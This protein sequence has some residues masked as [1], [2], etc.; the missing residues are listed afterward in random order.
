M[1]TP[2]SQWFVESFHLHSPIEEFEQFSRIEAERQRAEQPSI[3]DS[4]HREATEL[5]LRKLRPIPRA[6]RRRSTG[7]NDGQRAN[8]MDPDK[9]GRRASEPGVSP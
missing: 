6:D 7:T 1:Q 8:S 2:D 5:V 4:V 9:D 3:D